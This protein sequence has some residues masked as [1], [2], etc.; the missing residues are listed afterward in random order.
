MASAI[1]RFLYG[2]A[3]DLVSADGQVGDFFVAEMR[4][5]EG[6][7]ALRLASDRQPYVF[8]WVRFP[9]AGL[10]SFS[11]SAVEPDDLLLP[12][13]IIG[14]HSWECANGFWQF[15]LNCHRSRWSWNSRWPEVE[16]V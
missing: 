5:A 4:L 2:E 1:E 14:F 7:V 3:A 13:E 8:R 9:E 6:L 10:N 15:N 12:W 11:Q 16:N